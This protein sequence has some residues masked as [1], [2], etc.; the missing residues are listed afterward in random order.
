M[1]DA[2]SR[3]QHHVNAHQQWCDRMGF[4]DRKFDHCE[5]SNQYHKLIRDFYDWAYSDYV[6]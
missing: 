3:A 4:A 5:E 6:N 2:V 1:V